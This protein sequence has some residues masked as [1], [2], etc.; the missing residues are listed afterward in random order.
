ML[1]LPEHM[2]KPSRIIILPKELSNQIAAGEVVERP[3]SLVKELVENSLDAGATM[4]EVE[5]NANGTALRITDNGTGMTQEEAELSFHRHATSKIRNSDDL[6]SIKTLGFRGEA[7]PSIA[8]VCRLSLTTRTNEEMAG[9]FF[10]MQAGKQVGPGREVG[11][12]VGTQI[13]IKD[14]FYNVPARLK[15][16]KSDATEFGHIQET[17]VRLALSF[18]KVHF[19][20]KRLGKTV[21]DLP[22]HGRLLDRAQAALKLHGMGTE[23]ALL[24][25][26]LYRQEGIDIEACLSDPSQSASSSRNVYLFVNQRFVRD[27]SLIHAITSGYGGTLESGRFPVAVVHLHI[28]EAEVDVNVHPQKLE[29]RFAKPQALYAA[30][31][32]TIQRLVVK[33]PWLLS[34]TSVYPT[35][36]YPRLERSLMEAAEPTSQYGSAWYRNSEA[37]RPLHHIQKIQ[38]AEKIQPTFFDLSSPLE[39]IAPTASSEARFQNPSEAKLR[40]SEL[41]YLGQFAKTYLVCALENELLLIDQHAAH[42]RLAFERL[43]SAQSQRKMKAQRLL[44]PM[45]LEFDALRMALIEEQ[46]PLLEELGFELRHFGQ[47]TFA[48]MSIP[49]IAEFGRG[50]QVHQE[51]KKLLEKVLDDL[52]HGGRITSLQTRIEH[53]LATIACHSV[54]RAGDVLDE[55]QAKAL[56]RSMDEF[57]FA[58]YC[59][60]GRPV[61]IRMTKLEIEKRFGR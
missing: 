36:T 8:A 55:A 54:V 30:L 11:A 35:S 53:V 29:V 7:L 10:S 44:F 34:E 24:Y 45:H 3:A 59:P 19:R 17:L 31:F 61:L 49:D 43:K 13:E 5:S 50:A 9:F 60:H 26:S 46:I 22:P 4:I 23:D 41:P 51:P 48:L 6:F 14:L 38:H 2:S 58:P 47:T 27:R 33:A 15:F 1:V 40:F 28:P 21:L 52:D 20:L 37:P 32:E 16:M 18:P 57:E 39:A 25:P 42:E 56:L 12:P